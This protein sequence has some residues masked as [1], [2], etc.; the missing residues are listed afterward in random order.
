VVSASLAD[1]TYVRGRFQPLV[2]KGTIVP[3]PLAML[4]ALTIAFVPRYQGSVV[5]DHGPRSDFLSVTAPTLLTVLTQSAGSHFGQ[6][7]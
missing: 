3:M 6:S 4:T 7:E 5:G 2:L 1:S